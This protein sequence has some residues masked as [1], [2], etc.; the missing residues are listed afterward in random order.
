[1][2]E[3][4]TMYLPVNQNWNKYLENCQN[5]FEDSQNILKNL[6]EKSANEACKFNDEWQ[7]D[8]W[9]F[10]LDWSTKDFK[11]NKTTSKGQKTDADFIKSIINND[12]VIQENPLYKISSKKDK[13][14]VI[15]ILNFSFC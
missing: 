1:M 9:L 14:L 13:A 4:S 10:S 8:P 6:L 7:N 3:M 12:E 5:A 15:L 2:L 11:L